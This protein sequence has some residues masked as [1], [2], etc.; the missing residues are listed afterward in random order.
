MKYDKQDVQDQVEIVRDGYEEPPFNCTPL[1]NFTKTDKLNKKEPAF[2]VNS[3]N[4]MV[5]MLV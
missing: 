4:S 5:A 3:L 2:F 1:T